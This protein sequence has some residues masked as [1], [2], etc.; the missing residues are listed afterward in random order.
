MSAATTCRFCGKN[1]VGDKTKRCL[2][3]GADNSD[4]AWKSEAE[5]NRAYDDAVA[6]RDWQTCEILLAE[7]ESCDWYSP[8]VPDTEQKS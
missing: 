4:A 7:R 1:G 6:W 8:D 3:C 2:V 5:W